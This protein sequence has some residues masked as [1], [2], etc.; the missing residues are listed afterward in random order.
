M[1]VVNALGGFGGE[2]SSYGFLQRHTAVPFSVIQRP[3]DPFM[4]DRMFVD[5]SLLKVPWPPVPVTSVKPLRPLDAQTAPSSSP[6][7]R[8]SRLG[9]C[10]FPSRPPFCSF[11]VLCP[12]LSLVLNQEL[13]ATANAGFLRGRGQ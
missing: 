12:R 5:T 4:P 2:I 3:V 9:S 10:S 8:A 6:R 1:T 7:F 13:L 11:A